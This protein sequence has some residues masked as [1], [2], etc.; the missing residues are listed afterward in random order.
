ML[1]ATA[2]DQ[3]DNAVRALRLGVARVASPGRYRAA[4]VSR[5]LGRLLG[6]GSYL[7]R[8]QQA[9]AFLA[10]EDGAARGARI[11]LDTLEQLG[12]N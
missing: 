11:V 3:P 8:A 10:A 4:A 7:A 12:S 9:A 6:D 1:P 2:V 5:D